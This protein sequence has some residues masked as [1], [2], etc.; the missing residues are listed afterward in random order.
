VH[1]PTIHTKDNNNICLVV[2]QRRIV[3]F[4]HVDQRKR[5]KVSRYTED[6][7]IC[8][9]PVRVAHSENKTA[10]DSKKNR[11]KRQEKKKAKRIVAL[12]AVE[13]EDDIDDGQR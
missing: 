5:R 6:I 3:D 7:I 4:R 2:P 12:N 8:K 10:Y 9:R 13:E 1:I 11:V